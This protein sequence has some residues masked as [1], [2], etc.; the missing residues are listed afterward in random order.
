MSARDCRCGHSRDA[1][2]HHHAGT[3]KLAV[4]FVVDNTIG[5]FARWAFRD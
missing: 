3:S 1:H 4:V 2:R 5:R